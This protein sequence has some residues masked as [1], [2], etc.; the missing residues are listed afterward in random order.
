MKINGIHNIYE[1][2]QSQMNSSVEKAKKVS[3]KD[4]VSLSNNAKDFSSVYKM[5]SEVPDVRTQKVEQIKQAMN[6]GTYNVSS[7]QV[8]EKI[9]SQFNVKG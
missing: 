2:Y 5:L 9:L 6:S 7:E 3:E 4:Q 8:A 1:A